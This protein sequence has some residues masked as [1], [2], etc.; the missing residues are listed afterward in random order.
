VSCYF[1]GGTPHTIC[2]AGDDGWYAIA[3]PACETAAFPFGHWPAPTC[4]DGSFGASDYSF[5]L[6]R[7]M[8]DYGRAYYPTEGYDVR[9]GCYLQ[10]GEYDLV[11]VG[12]GDCPLCWPG[13]LGC[14][15][16]V[17]G[18]CDGDAV[19]VVADNDADICALP[20]DG[21]CPSGAVYHQ[22]GCLDACSQYDDCGLAV[23]SP[24]GPY[25]VDGI[26]AWP[27]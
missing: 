15:C 11:S 24:V 17:E 2:F 5:V 1:V 27:N 21:S 19:C 18:T 9:P 20:S 26:C 7:Q 14:A 6:A 12:P 23:C 4:T 10:S 16:T 25:A 13:S 22:G 3:R 8:G